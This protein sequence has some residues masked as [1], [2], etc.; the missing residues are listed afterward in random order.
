MAAEQ[1][2]ILASLVIYNAVLLLIG[3]WATRRTAGVD[4]FLIGGRGL[5][6]WVAGLSYAAT[7]SSA[8]VLL[9]FSGFVYSVGV[10]ALWMLPGIWFGY[11]AVWMIIGGRLQREAAERK[12]ITLTDFMIADMPARQRPPIAL[13]ASVML[14]FCFLFYIAAQLQA[15]G[16]AMTTYFE[17][18][19][20]D[21]VIISALIIG[22]YSLLGGF[23]AISVTDMV[24][25]L[26]MA[27]VA[28]AAPVATVVAAGGVV[29]VFRTL[30]AES[31]KHLLPFGGAAG[32]VAIG[33]A[34]GAASIGLGTLGQPQLL[35]RVMAVRDARARQ[36]AFAISF[37]WAIIVFASMAMLGLS[38]RALALTLDN[39]EALL[40]TVIDS[41]FPP[42]FTGVA[43]AALLSAIMSTVD[44][45]LLS[46]SAA[47]SHDIGVARMA[48]RRSLMIARLSTALLM[49]LAVVIALAAPAAIFDRVLFAW[50]ALG[51]AFGPIIV[52][53]VIG[54]RHD[55]PAL[56]AAMMMGFGLAVAF[57]QVW[58]AGPGNL[59]ERV[60]PWAAALMLLF[61]SRKGKAR[62]A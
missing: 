8:W 32:F 5:G 57:N 37:V 20:R 33:A 13:L 46:S 49:A 35:A 45:L 18:P 14:L 36:R 58:P 2:T 23:W 40:F 26:M 43:L 27:F 56:G 38:G 15:A 53:R 39:P 19:I 16:G 31:P 21:A 12:H 4:D 3:V 30:A 55:G 42:F 61:L 60:L 34:I 9:G 7:S 28:V 54:W 25:G 47:I 44:S 1:A 59:Y 48:P 50:T 52:S 10:S 62:D 41:Y 51:A 6:A 11:V 22:A 29:E 24:Q 17:M